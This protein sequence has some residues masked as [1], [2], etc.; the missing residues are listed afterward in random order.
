MLSEDHRRR[1]AEAL[2][3]RDADDIPKV[4]GAGGVRVDEMGNRIQIMHNGVAVV[5]DGYYGEFITETVERLKGHHEPQDEKAFHE[6]LKVIPAGSTMIELGAYWSYYSMWFQK[7]IKGARNFMIEPIER[8]LECGVK[9]FQLNRMH[10]DFTRAYIGRCSSEGWEQ[11]GVPG[12]SGEAGRVC[13]K[14]FAQSKGIDAVTLLHSDIQGYEYE[15]LRGCGDLI[16]RKKIEVLFISSHSLKVHYQC[17]T[18]LTQRGYSILAEH[19]PKESYSEDGLI[20][21]SASLRPLERI[22]LSKKPM[23]VRLRWKTAL[24]RAVF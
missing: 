9:N 18:Y 8:C 21:A 6:I 14:D 22:E 24:F 13:I 19:N 11:A 15:M 3:C 12:A 10:G 7:S 5:A 23:S 20:V 2:A 1:V 17:R 16:G 4:P